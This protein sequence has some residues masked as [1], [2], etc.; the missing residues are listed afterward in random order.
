MVVVNNQYGKLALNAITD[1]NC[2]RNADTIKILFDIT[3]YENDMIDI[4]I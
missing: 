3:D 2:V 1:S 4:K